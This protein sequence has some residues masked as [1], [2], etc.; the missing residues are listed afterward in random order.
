MEFDDDDR[1]IP[2]DEYK[3]EVAY[4]KE[5]IYNALVMLISDIMDVKLELKAC[6]EKIEIQPDPSP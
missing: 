6:N 4:H 2:L 1:E 3:T 5:Q